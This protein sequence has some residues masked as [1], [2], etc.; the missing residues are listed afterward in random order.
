MTAPKNFLL[1]CADEFRPD[2]LGCAGH[3]VVRTPNL[4]ALARRGTRFSRAYTPSPICVSARAAMACGDYVHRIRCWDSATPYG[5][6]PQSWMHALRDNGVTVSSIGKLHFRSGEDDNGFS[7]EILPMHVVGGIGWAI[8]LLRENP[9][10]FDG[11]R[12]LA[13]GVGTGGSSYSEY[14]A[15][16]C[17]AAEQWIGDR[18]ADGKPWS[19]FVSFVSPHFPLNPPE[20][21]AR[22][23]PWREMEWPVG[24]DEQA[25]LRH[26]ETKAIADFY[27]YGRHFDP[28]T[29]RKAK[30]AYFGLVSFV[31][32]CVGRLVRALERTGQADDTVIVFTSDHG[33][34]LGDLGLWTKMVMYEQSAGV[35]MILAGPDVPRG[36]TVSTPV[37]LL[38]IAPTALAV[39]GTT[40]CGEW[41]ER[42][43][44]SLLD[45]AGAPDDPD[46]T[47]FSEY[48][49]GGSTTGAYMVRWRQWK[50]VHYVGRPAQL[51]DLG[52]DP[53]ELADLAGLADRERHVADAVAEGLRR[54]YQI[55]DPDSVNASAFSDQKQRIESLGGETACRDAYVFNHTPTPSEQR[56]LSDEL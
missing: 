20:E 36:R 48:H 37:S 47:A 40:G 51:F 50:Y 21:F 5:G 32:D 23:Y 33:E 4:D 19:A 43:G 42:P 44:A 31:D 14:D 24:Y 49:D 27:D 7:E 46:R 39:T 12:E 45:L 3:R 34:M 15:D 35:P 10:F 28:E 25:G 17:K 53:C 11:G 1:I 56:A 26:P 54:L 22:L 6:A 52:S 41:R 30:A 16:I 2:A 29:V 8:G 38:D 18:A 13:A 55:C 9:P